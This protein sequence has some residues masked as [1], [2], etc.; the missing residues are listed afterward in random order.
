MACL[1]HASELEDAIA[2][3][4]LH[5]LVRRGDPRDRARVLGRR[6]GAAT[7]R[8]GG[9]R[10]LG[11]AAP[12]GVINADHAIGMNGGEAF[13]TNAG[14]DLAEA[15]YSAAFGP[16][17]FLTAYVELYG[18]QVRHSRGF[19][20]QNDVGSQRRWI[21][22]NGFAGGQERRVVLFFGQNGSDATLWS[23][24]STNDVL[25]AG[26]AW[27]GLLFVRLKMNE[28]VAGDRGYVA[29]FDRATG[30]WTP[31][32]WGAPGG[33]PATSLTTNT[34]KLTVCNWNNRAGI[35]G[36]TA[37]PLFWGFHDVALDDSE[38]DIVASKALV[39]RG[40]VDIFIPP[41]TDGTTFTGRNG[42]VVTMKGSGAGKEPRAIRVGQMSPLTR[43]VLV[44]PTLDATPARVD[45]TGRRHYG[46]SG[47]KVG[48]GG[49]PAGGTMNIT[50]VADAALY[51]PVD[52]VPTF[53]IFEGCTNDIP[54]DGINGAQAIARNQQ[55]IRNYTVG[56][57]TRRVFYCDIPPS[58]T[59]AQQTEF[60]AHNAGKAA[61][62]T[63]LLGEGILVTAINDAGSLDS[64]NDYIDA[65]HFGAAG[66]AKLAKARYAVVKPFLPA[67]GPFRI[68]FLGNSHVSGSGWNESG[69][70][71]NVGGWKVEFVCC[72]ARDGY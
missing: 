40:L 37:Y 30:L 71:A 4:E 6:P 46:V 59:P 67:S 42:T 24:T 10:G 18:N 28:A 44:G 58:R 55:L 13:G 26:S 53:I 21:A 36:L 48:D 61:A 60:D 63:T 50:A 12:S 22:T 64:A 32:T 70:P 68:L 49:A 56:D 8:R 54:L 69:T 5:E 1:A 47:K 2:D 33:A 3:R 41:H 65:N 38:K 57:L 45:A 34:A 51:L 16:T 7:G 35:N 43:C 29:F 23:L 20:G 15:A 27:K 25:P 17:V 14:G 72:L 9:F 66:A 19:I 62:I 39:K 11:G 52:G 31:A